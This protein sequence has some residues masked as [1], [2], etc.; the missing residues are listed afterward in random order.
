MTGDSEDGLR[1]YTGFELDSG[2]VG[3]S[4][5]GDVR[6]LHKSCMN[7][8]VTGQTVRDLST[9]RHAFGEI[10]KVFGY[11]CLKHSSA[12]RWWRNSKCL[13]FERWFTKHF[14]CQAWGT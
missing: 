10:L 2:G 5:I 13:A 1:F 7:I 11:V 12:R 4:K 9:R 14:I 6:I 3:Q 8:A